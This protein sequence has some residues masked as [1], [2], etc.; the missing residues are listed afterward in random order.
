MKIGILTYYKVKNFGANLQAV[1]TYCYLKNHGHEPI[2]INYILKE[3]L[4]AIEDGKD[5]PQWHAHLGFVDSV[6]S[7]QSSLCQTS[8]EVLKVCSDFKLDGLIA[9]SDALLQHHPFWARIKRGKR[10]PIYLQ[11]FTSD[12]LFPNLFWGCGLADRI[13]MAL[14]SV[15]SQNSKYKLF[16][17][18]TKDSMKKTLECMRYISVRD[19]WTRDMIK[20]VM[21]NDVLITPDPVFA[22]NQNAGSIVPTI[23]EVRSRFHLPEKYILL[24]L[25]NQCLSES[26]ISELRCK[27]NKEDIS[28]VILPMPFGVKFKHNA[29]I[30]I[31]MPLSPI[32]WYALL[33]YATG[34]IG[35][36]MHPIVSCLHNAVPCFSL[37]NYGCTDFFG[38]K[39]DD[40][41]SKIEH[42][43]KVM[44]VENNRRIIENEKCTVS[45]DEIINGL[46]TFPKDV[47]RERAD[48]YLRQYNE[49]MSTII[50]KL[51]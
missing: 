29:D 17:V 45:V 49:M 42:I 8:D 11:K 24:S 50:S 36:N 31:P 37:D 33:K 4:K 18:S 1:S 2:F 6:I 47:V 9:G 44:G 39:K 16:S 34:Y 35:S 27:L 43:M 48:L 15:S 22:F 3:Q 46:K 5:D 14:M 32:D 25:F 38:R 13:P 21:G 7:H 20:D 28:L 51:K 10:R 19:T 23:E 40:G 26:F 41:S 30:E 12:R